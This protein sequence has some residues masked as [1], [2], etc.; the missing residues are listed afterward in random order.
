MSSLPGTPRQRG[1][2]PH[3]PPARLAHSTQKLHLVRASP[4]RVGYTGS[5]DYTRKMSNCALPKS[6]IL[7]TIGNIHTPQ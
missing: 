7:P 6:P 5:V 2:R 3:K 4:I 1:S